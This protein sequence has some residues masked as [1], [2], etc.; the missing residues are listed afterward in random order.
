M[1]RFDFSVGSLIHGFNTDTHILEIFNALLEVK[2]YIEYFSQDS[3][4]NNKV[5]KEMFDNVYF[6]N[7]YKIIY[8]KED[9]YELLILVNVKDISAK[10]SFFFIENK[11]RYIFP[12]IQ[13]KDSDILDINSLLENVITKDRHNFITNCLLSYL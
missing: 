7:S 1:Y 10:P 6:A 5:L 12:L 8:F 9:I 4:F 2:E 13:E 3:H 11:D